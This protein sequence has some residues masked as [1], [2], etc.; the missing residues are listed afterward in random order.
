[1]EDGA[2][3]SEVRGLNDLSTPELEYR[4]DSENDLEE[5]ESLSCWVVFK[6]MF[7]SYSKEGG[8]L[9]SEQEKVRAIKGGVG[10]GSRN[11]WVFNSSEVPEPPE[12]KSRV[13]RWRI[14]EGEI[15]GSGMRREEG[16]G[17]HCG[18]RSKRGG[19]NLSEDLLR[20]QTFS[21]CNRCRGLV[22]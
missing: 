7:T 12:V 22:L 19:G 10:K 11:V 2:R 14:W 4:V 21:L 13:R 1:M 8:E 16:R 20:F 15:T 6:D 17:A 5:R 3:E 9:R 18:A